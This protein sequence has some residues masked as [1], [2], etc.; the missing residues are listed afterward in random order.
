MRRPDAE[1]S[2]LIKDPRVRVAFVKQETY[3]V[4]RALRPVAFYSRTAVRVTGF[5]RREISPD[6]TPLSRR[7]IIPISASNVS[8]EPRGKHNFS[9][10]TYVVAATIK[11]SE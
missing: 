1:L 3:A 5:I 2:E 10:T 4:S 9:K 8:P 7:S 11:W 6:E